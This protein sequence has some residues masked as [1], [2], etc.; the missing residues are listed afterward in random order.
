VTIFCFTT[1]RALVIV[2][3]NFPRAFRI[4]S[5]FLWSLRD[6]TKPMS[7]QNGTYSSAQLRERDQRV[8]ET[9][10][11]EI[12]ALDAKIQKLRQNYD[13]VSN[14]LFS[15]ANRERRLVEALGF[16]SVYE[17]QIAID[18]TDYPISFRNC[19]ERVQTAEAQL[20]IE[21]KEVELLQA[22]LRDI[23]GENKLLTAKYQYVSNH[24]LLHMLRMVQDPGIEIRRYG[25]CEDSRC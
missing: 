6:W 19:M 21:K 25:S 9:R 22:K 14:E 4:Y 15:V 11:K 2:I 18:S 24:S 5:Q 7:P 20:H 16:E 1:R 3:P 8:N 17:A 10:Q 13:S 23:E 12:D